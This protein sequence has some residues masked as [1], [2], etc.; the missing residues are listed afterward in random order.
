MPP[1]L[2]P[3]GVCEPLLVPDGGWPA[4]GAATDAVR[5]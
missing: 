4:A 5:G 2:L 1:L 3:L